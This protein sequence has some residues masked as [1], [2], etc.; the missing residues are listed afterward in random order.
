VERVLIAVAIVA[1]AAVVA[2]VLRSR[3]RPDAP[4]QPR[5][6]A[7]TQLDRSDFDHADRE[8][9]LVA[10]T[11]ESC[12]TCADVARKAAAAAT[13]MVGFVEVEYGTSRDLHERYA[14]TG[15]PTL[16]LADRSGVVRTSFLGPVTATDLWA[17]V[18]EARDPGSM[19][20]S[21]GHH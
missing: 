3:Q 12:H 1:V 2:L 5:H 10:F 9:L 21:C 17:A 18:A 4:T 16:V 11:S 15:V 19:P 8:W 6:D 20:P 13:P 14:I 7:P